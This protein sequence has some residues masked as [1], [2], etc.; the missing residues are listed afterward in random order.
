MKLLNF[1]K[2]CRHLK[3]IVISF[4]LII[5]IISACLLLWQCSMFSMLFCLSIMQK[6]NIISNNVC[7]H[8]AF[9]GYH[10]L[11]YVI[12]WISRCT[13]KGKLNIIFQVSYLD[14]YLQVPFCNNGTI[15]SISSSI[16]IDCQKYVGYLSVYRICFILT[17]FFLLMAIM[18]LGV[19]SSRDPRAGI[20][21]G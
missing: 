14:D 11:Y 1:N 20:Q 18:M 6:F 21:N 17:L 16:V 9:G 19:K 3:Y 12:T 5:F 10:L 2:S 7:P 4:V 8:V 15:S 13:K